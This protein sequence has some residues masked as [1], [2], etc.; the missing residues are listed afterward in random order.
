MK[1]LAI[2]KDSLREALDTKV[3]YVMVGFSLLVVLFIGSVGYRPVSVEEEARRNMAR[4]TWFMQRIFSKNNA[5]EAPT[6]DVKDF[7][8]T[9]PSA[10]PWETGY[11]F[12]LTLEFRQPPTRRRPSVSPRNNPSPRSKKDYRPNSP[13]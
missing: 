8:Q 3:F 2:L 12:A 4:M 7:E 6:W 1:F 11:R 9:N 13:T 5:G 10:P